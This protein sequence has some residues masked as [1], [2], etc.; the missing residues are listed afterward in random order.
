MGFANC[1]N[2]KKALLTLLFGVLFSLPSF[3]DIVEL[4]S[5]Y[6]VSTEGTPLPFYRSGYGYQFCLRETSSSGN[7][8]LQLPTSFSS[9]SDNTLY[10]SGTISGYATDVRNW[11]NLFFDA[12][13]NRPWNAPGSYFIIRC[14]FPTSD[15]DFNS[16]VD[17]LLSGQSSVYCDTGT[18][19]SAADGGVNVDCYLYNPDDG[20]NSFYLISRQA[21]DIGYVANGIGNFHLTFYFD[22]IHQSTNSISIAMNTLGYYGENPFFTVLPPTPE[23]IQAQKL[24]NINLLLA[25]LQQGFQSSIDWLTYN[26]TNNISGLPS[27]STHIISVESIDEEGEEITTTKSYNYPSYFEYNITIQDEAIDIQ[28][29]ERTGTFTGILHRKFNEFLEFWRCQ[30]ALLRAWYYPLTSNELPQYWRVYNSDTGNVQSVNPATITYYITWYLG[31]LY[32]HLTANIDAVL[33]QPVKDTKQAI[34]DL[35]ASEAKIR[36]EYLPNIQNFEF[37]KDA[38]GTLAALGFCRD[39][40]QNMFLSL[41]GFNLVIVMALSLGVA[42]QAIGYFKFRQ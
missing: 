9:L 38:I 8:N 13:F 7:L 4:P 37:N 14:N 41:G 34:A 11:N 39:L 18:G 22:P 33:E 32:E 23:E 19:P 26:V 2:L 35:E 24:S 5:N 16:V 30:F 10:L 6:I 25:N 40:L 15:I 27:G 31:K 1:Y 42:M 21:Y 29:F 28:S 36:N 17:N 3:A 20:S 12:M